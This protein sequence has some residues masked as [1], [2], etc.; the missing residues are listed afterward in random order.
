MDFITSSSCMV[1]SNLL[2]WKLLIFKSQSRVKS[3]IEYLDLHNEFG[4]TL[5][6]C[7]DN[8]QFYMYIVLKEL[9]G[10]Y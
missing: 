5:W 10:I 9:N 1:G 8:I 3:L 6:S 4:Y 2:I 7:F